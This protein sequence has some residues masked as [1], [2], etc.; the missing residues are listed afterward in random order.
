[1][2]FIGGKLLAIIVIVDVS[3]I[4]GNGIFGKLTFGMVLSG[5]LLNGFKAFCSKLVVVADETEIDSLDKEFAFCCCTTTG[6]T[7]TDF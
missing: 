1:M 7:V 3:G 2:R 4:V 5:I 6:V